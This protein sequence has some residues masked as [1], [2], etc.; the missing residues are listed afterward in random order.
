MLNLFF[1]N[2]N[3]SYSAV[4]ASEPLPVTIGSVSFDTTGLATEASADRAADALEAMLADGSNTPVVVAPALFETVA[5]SV[6]DQMMGTTGAVGDTLAGLLV[7]PTAT[8]V[9]PI[10]IEYGSTNTQVYAGGTVGADLK[11]FVIP[12]FNIATPSGGGWEITT[13]VGCSV[14]AFG[15]FT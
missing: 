8:T 1:K 13:G 11:P 14:I 15:K 6:T 5:A 10:S 2:A 9:G 7:T 12:L 4:S 3:G